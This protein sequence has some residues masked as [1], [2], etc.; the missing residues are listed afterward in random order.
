VRAIA[1]SPD[2]TKLA[3]SSLDDTVRLW[4][5]G[6][7]RE[8]YRLPGHGA[9]GGWRFLSF[10]PDGRRFLSFGDD[11]Y[12]RAWDVRTG[13]A[14]LE[15]AIRPAGIQV[16]DEDADDAPGEM[17]GMDITTAAFTS[18]GKT[19]LLG[20]FRDQKLHLFDVATGKEVRAFDRVDHNFSSVALSPDGKYLLASTS[21]QYGRTEL[22]N[23]KFLL[24]EP[25]S[26]P[27]YL[28]DLA[29][30]KEARRV[31]LP[32][33]NGG[34]VAFAPDGK[35]FA[36]TAGPPRGQIKFWDTVTGAERGTIEGVPD[37]ARVLAFSP[38]GK[39]V[40]TALR[41]TSALVWDVTKALKRKP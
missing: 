40:I 12:L 7:G 27:I 15:H 11:F 19:L 2:G 26:H 17:L 41:D 18:D 23:R 38:D 8:I 37:H 5:T 13:K 25:L 29:T 31:L 34:A 3:S 16:P 35:L 21:G 20:T 14:L 24:I 4:D 9:L 10:T 28:I 22:P 1:L 32:G 30:G 33:Q 36:A 6:T 39:Q